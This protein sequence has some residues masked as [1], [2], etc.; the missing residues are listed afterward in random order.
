[1]R[2]FHQ[3]CE[4]NGIMHDHEE[5]FNYLRTYENHRLNLLILFKK[6][7]AEVFLNNCLINNIEYP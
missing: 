3:I 4:E 1:M 5:I 2:L 6:T 7:S